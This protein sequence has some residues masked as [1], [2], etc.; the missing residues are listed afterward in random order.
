MVVLLMINKSF[1]FQ[2]NVGNLFVV[3]LTEVDKINM[4][5][6]DEIVEFLVTLF[7]MH[8]CVDSNAFTASARYES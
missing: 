3:I 5:N 2:E 7:G 1:S 8:L 6:N 4:L